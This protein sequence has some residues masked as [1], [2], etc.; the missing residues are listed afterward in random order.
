MG[1]FKSKIQIQ[2]SFI[3]F[4]Q[5]IGSIPGADY[6]MVTSFL[7][8]MTFFILVGVYLLLADKEEMKIMDNKPLE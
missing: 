8:F 1:R 6:F 4:K 2:N 5:F 7:M 3:M